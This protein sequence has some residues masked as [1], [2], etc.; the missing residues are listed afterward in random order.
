[1]IY[2]SVN[3]PGLRFTQLGGYAKTP[4]RGEVLGEEHDQY[5]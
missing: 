4:D 2:I 3:Y 1:M 5:S